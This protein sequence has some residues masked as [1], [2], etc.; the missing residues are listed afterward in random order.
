M[1][2]IA[3]SERLLCWWETKGQTTIRHQKVPTSPVVP[4]KI[5]QACEGLL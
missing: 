5:P 2:K 3:W 4:I 1:D